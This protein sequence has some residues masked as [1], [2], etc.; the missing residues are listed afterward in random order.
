[1]KTDIISS[2]KQ[3]FAKKTDSKNYSNEENENSLIQREFIKNSPFEAIKHEK[4]GWFAVFGKQKISNEYKTKQDLL[5]Q[6]EAVNW[7]ILMNA[8][9]VMTKAVLK[10]EMEETIK[11]AK[12]LLN[13]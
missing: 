5:N 11:Q 13:K 3:L 1:M 9:L 4:S 12:E 2:I 8:V 6:F 7:E 10:E